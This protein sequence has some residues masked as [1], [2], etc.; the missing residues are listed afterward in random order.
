MHLLMY[1][2]ALKRERDTQKKTSTAYHSLLGFILTSSATP[3]TVSYLL[4]QVQWAE[5][6]RKTQH[7]LHTSKMLGVKL[8]ISQYNNY[9]YYINYH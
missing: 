5:L 7:M 3:V 9:Y 8:Y 6:A 4:G 2:G 1:R